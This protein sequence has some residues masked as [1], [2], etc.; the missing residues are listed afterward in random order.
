[1]D[2]DKHDKSVKD[3]ITLMYETSLLMSGFA[4]ENPQ[5]HAERIFRMVSLGLGIDESE[6][7]EKS[8]EAAKPVPVEEMPPLEEASRMEEVD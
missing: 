7:G 8:E 5:S 2:A 6:V 4:P 3:V 1:M